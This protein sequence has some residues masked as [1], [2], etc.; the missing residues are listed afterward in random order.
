MNFIRSNFILSM[1]LKRTGFSLLT[2]FTISILIFVGVEA[3]PGDTAEAI[4]GQGAT[5][6]N[7]A[8]LRHEL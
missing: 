2:L 4:L 3:L 8:A 5:P 1:V 6:E 7:V